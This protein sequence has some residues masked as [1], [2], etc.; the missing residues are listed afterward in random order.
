MK[1]ANGP[2]IL[3][4]VFL[5]YGSLALAGAAASDADALT[6]MLH[7]FLANAYV[8]AAHERFWARDLVY[9]SSNG[10]RFGKAD[11]LAG[12]A[13]EDATGEPPTVVY[14]AADIDVRVFDGTAVVAFR[15]IGTPSDGAPAL[16]YFN[17][18]T[19]LKR[20]G[21]W[22]VVA[23]QATTIAGNEEGGG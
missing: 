11:I 6:E 22:Q 3:K 9:T 10:R 13:D 17:T 23:W 8:E 18:G 12:F 2:A 16:E 1:H 15:L 5:L 14:S 21:R 20:D 4:I 19:F 7:E